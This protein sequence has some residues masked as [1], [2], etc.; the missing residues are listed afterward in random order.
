MIKRDKKMKFESKIY[1]VINI[2]KRTKAKG[3]CDIQIGDRLWFYIDLKNTLGASNGLYALY[4][5]THHHGIREKIFKFYNNW[6]NSQNDFLRF[7][8][9][10]ELKEL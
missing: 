6:E 1:E 5:K 9:N 3:F 2:L 10:F 7:I 4:V 8:S